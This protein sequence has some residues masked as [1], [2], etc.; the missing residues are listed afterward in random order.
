MAE[1]NKKRGYPKIPKGSWF[2]L[3]DKFKQRIP[4]EVSPNY[5]ATALSMTPASASANVIPPL[6]TFGLI[7]DNGK[8]TDLAVHW[9]DDETYGEVCAT[10]IKNTYPSELH[11][12]FHSSDADPKKVAA[13]FARDGKVG[14]SAARMYSQTY[15]ML[16]EAD[17]DKAKEGPQPKAKPASKSSPAHSK[18]ATPKPA[19]SSAPATTNGSVGET[20]LQQQPPV[21][22]GAHTFS[23]KLHID[24]QIHISPESSP[25]QIDKI[26]ESMA[27]HLRD[28]RS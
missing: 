3:R 14:E 23:P 11:D 28:F 25:E 26:F 19:K 4:A 24:V 9:R 21:G 5:I 16:L 27:K 13:W 6:R 2:G 7:D 18:A 17:L 22:E 8:P 15:L 20:P 12:L 1:D 10:I